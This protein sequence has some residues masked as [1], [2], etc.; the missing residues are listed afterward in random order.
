MAIG[1]GCLPQAYKDVKLC[2]PRGPSGIFSQRWEL[3]AGGSLCRAEGIQ[4]PLQ[5]PCTTIAC[6]TL[7]SA[8]PFSGF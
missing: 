3:D 6:L 8:S 4:E 5:D 1:T 7:P 2:S